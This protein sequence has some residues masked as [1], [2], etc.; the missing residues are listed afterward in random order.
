MQ[1]LVNIGSSLRGVYQIRMGTQ[2]RVAKAFTSHKSQ[3][4]FHG[5]CE[6]DSHADTFVAGRNCLLMHY[7]ERVCNVMPY[8][9]EY[10]PKER[11]PIVQVATGYTSMNGVSYILIFN[12]ALWMPHLQNSLMNPNQLRFNGTKVQ[13]NP[14]DEE[15]MTIERDDDEQQFIACL[16]TEGTNIF[17]NTW[18]PTDN[19]LASYP[20]IVM[21]SAE[22]WDPHSVRFP[23]MTASEM[24]E[25]EDYN[26]MT[27]D[28]GSRGRKVVTEFGDCYHQPLRVFDIQVFNARIMQTSVGPY[29]DA[30]GPLSEK[31]LMPPKT[32]ISSKRHSNTTPEDLSEVWNISVEQAKMT[33]EA[34]T[35]HHSRSAVM[36]L[37]RRYRMDRMFEPKRLRCEMATDTMDP[38]CDGMHGTRYC[39]VFGSRHMFAEAYPITK[40]SD[41]HEA[42][43]TFLRDYG[44]PDSMIMDGSKEQT[45][46][47][48][49]FQATL[50]KNNVLPIITLP[51]RP[52]HNPS[53]S[54]I[55]ELRKKWYRAVFRTNC[56]RALWS[57]GLP[58]FAKLMQLTA[59]N[60]ANLNGRTPLEFV[61]GET[62]DISQY[63]DFGWYDWVWY[64]ENAGL[65][66]PKIGRFLGIADSASNIMT[67][68]ILPPSGIPVTAGTVQRITQLEL[69]TDAVKE[70]TT[71]F[72]EKIAVK[73]KEGRLQQDGDKPDLAAWEDLLEGDPDF[74]EE[75]NRLF[76]N[77]EVLEADD[78]FDPDSYDTYLNM[79]VSFDRGGEYPEHA[80]VTKR[81]RDTNGNPIGKANN[82]PILDTRMYELEFV[83]GYKQA[84]SANLIAENMFATVDEEGHRHLLLDSIIDTRKSAEAVD[85]ADAF[86]QSSNGTRRRRETTKGWEVLIQ[87]KDGTTTWSKLK[88]VKD[89]YPIQLAEYAIQ[90]HIDDEPAFAWWTSYVLKKKSRIISKVKSKYWERTHKYGIR[91]PKN[92]KEAI[93]IDKAN[94]NTLWWTALMQEMKNVRPAFEVHEGD[95][96]KLVGYQKIKCHVIWDVKLG[97]NFRRKARLVAGGHTT[98][99]PSSITY[100]SVVSRESVRIALTVAALNGLDILACDIQNAYLTADCREKIYTIAG[101][102]FGSEAGKVMIVKKALYGLKSSGAA[103]R[104]LLA[105]TI[106]DLNYR[107]SKA[108]PD[109]WMRAATKPNGFKYYELILCYVDDVISIS[110]TPMHAIEGIKAVFKLKGNKAE[111]P[112]MY[113]GGGIA[114]VS[115]AVGTPC[116][117]LSSEKYIKTAIA[118]VEEALEKENRKLPTKCI[119]PFSTGYHPSE[120]SSS[121]LDSSGTRY[122]QELI[123][124][125]RWAIELGRVDILLEVSLLSQHLALPRV[126]H[127]QQV[128]HVFGYL[129]QSPR[130]RLFFDPDHP[131]ISEDRFHKFEWEDFYKDATEDIP[132][133]AP[134]PLGNEVGIHC[135]V[136]ASHASD[137]VTRRSQTGVLIFINKAP[138]IFHSKRQNSV[139]TSTFGSE[140]TAMKQA[141]ELVKALR[142]KLRMFGVPIEGPASMY[143]DN[144]AVYKNVSIPSSVLN[145][146]MHGISYHYCR[147]AV[148]SGVARVA[149]EDTRTNLSDLFTKVLTRARREELLDKFMY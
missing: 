13:D 109:V 129:K 111:V 89:S 149:K 93:E 16:Q 126:G 58:H 97:E 52:N 34:T 141:I 75:F 51:A 21:T 71:A 28:S 15:P 30:S 76:D 136:D 127:L 145:K 100:S 61:T 38:R 128:Y 139:E 98:D 67:Y 148:A 131:K 143:C 10:A 123:G 25:I 60:A 42:L 49:K 27:L 32:F 103:F 63:L 118:S 4:V 57:Y 133:D 83:D 35:Q 48:T 108:D 3:K 31:E 138:I 62:P 134:E 50:R 86:I 114:K 90:N 17:I 29:T 19:D 8:S 47:N 110:N 92:V 104:S 36:P 140:F 144:E 117:T 18:T 84:V 6:L 78:T 107:P 2:Y 46:K 99:P 23:S 43:N 101:D 37:S 68:H 146:K 9:D 105:Q 119:L 147:E 132:I 137:K 125:L 85:K 69:Q 81:L 65:D 115:N 142:Y 87:W 74:A 5:R 44:A 70:R 40:K 112:E 80:R 22:V 20:K 72:T 26:V 79:E 14:F 113:L 130:R 116:W 94:E 124:V 64:K 41:C 12:E 121:E 11:V 39:Q 96:S 1:Y 66:V 55:R 106:W 7:T 77:P 82:N 24:N 95:A 135:F 102:E 45:Q 56:P 53:E 91:I 122:Y 73:F 54:V 33:L 59:S 120:D 88:D